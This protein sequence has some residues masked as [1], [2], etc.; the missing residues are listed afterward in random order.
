[1]ANKQE[2]KI[3]EPVPEGTD[4]DTAETKRTFASYTEAVK[5]RKRNEADQKKLHAERK[6]IDRACDQ[7]F[8]KTEKDSKKGRKKQK[9][10][11]NPDRKLSGIEKKCVIP[12][13]FLAFITK[14][15][16]A[17]KFTPEYIVILKDLELTDETEI[18]RGFITC[19]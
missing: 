9:R 11:P 13:K 6:E 19:L 8:V 4:Q 3:T 18:P 5:A 12:E 2:K 15:I 16:N 1:M 10:E 7:Y 17:K 14:G